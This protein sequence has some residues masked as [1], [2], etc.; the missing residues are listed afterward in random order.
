MERIIIIH[1]NKSTGPEPIIQYPPQSSYPSKELMLKIWAQHELNMD[2]IMI[3]LE[4]FQGDEDKKY[5]SIIQEFENELYFLVLIYDAHKIAIDIITPDI[6]A[7]INKNLL[8]L[9]N[10][11]K[12]NRAISEAFYTIKN[13]NQ[14]ESENL[15]NFF[16]DKIK[17]TI[18][19][20]LREGII[21]KAELTHKL[22]EEYGFS[23]VNID[24]L[25]ISFLRENLIK[26][27]IIAGSKECYL[28]IN[29]LS[30]VRVP[31]NTLPKETTDEKIL[32]RYKKEYA[33]FYANYDSGKEIEDKRLFNFLLDKD[34]FNLIK[35]L[36]KTDLSVNDCLIILNNKEELFSELLEAQII[37]ESRGLVFLFSDIRFVKF[38]PFFIINKLNTR[39]EKQEISL[40]QYISHVEYFLNILKTTPNYLNYSLI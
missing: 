38:I 3:E 30:F 16:H 5:I 32:K 9:M 8:E 26:K 40:N 31:P 25:L 6:L 1:W 34:V 29:D 22:R 24:L 23:T 39:Y 15:I 7:T 19:E 35:A 14:L 18:L 37:F 21:S 11:D 17:C 33:K 12:I 27:Q 10:T 20:I 36:R 13:F 2:K 4:R 28:L